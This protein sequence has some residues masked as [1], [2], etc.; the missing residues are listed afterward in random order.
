MQ[1]YF[2]L[3]CSYESSDNMVLECLASGSWNNVV[4][5]CHA[6]SCGNPIAIANGIYTG[7]EST[8]T[9]T[10]SNV[11]QYNCNKGKKEHDFACLLVP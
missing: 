6:V 2:L 4:P 3:N 1:V 9:Q 11:V 10:Y 7:G 5:S 8:D